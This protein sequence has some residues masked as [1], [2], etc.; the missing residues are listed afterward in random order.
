MTKPHIHF[1]GKNFGDIFEIHNILSKCP[2]FDTTHDFYNT[3]EK[4]GSDGDF[5]ITSH[6]TP[7]QYHG[8]VIHCQH[9]FGVA[10][11]VTYADPVKFKADYCT[12]YYALMLYGDQ[13]AKDYTKVGFPENKI[14]VVG[15]PASI[16]LLEVTPKLK[17]KF[18]NS[19][20]F[21]TDRKTVC[22][23]PSWDMG[24]PRG[25]FALWHKDGKERIRVEKFCKF[26][27]HTLGCNLIIRMH[28][29][30]RYSQDWGAKYNDIFKNY[31]VFFT[32][33]DQQPSFNKA[34]KYSD[35]FVGDYSNTNTYVYIMNKPIVHIGSKPL[36]RW[37]NKNGGWPMEDRDG[38][39]TDDF[40]QL[41]KQIAD[42]LEHPEKFS[43]RRIEVVRKNI[44]YTGTDCI[45][46]VISEF[47]ELILV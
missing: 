45:R 35:I 27:T 9:G 41:L 28:E 39:I 32:Y 25:L 26:I 29:R 47:K 31:N 37:A 11:R 2:E 19:A 13:Q 4:T 16:P 3:G 46:P 24:T 21:N 23:I 20:G 22:Y 17:I 5:V 15:C 7:K 44:K 10:S 36:K 34:L 1:Y 14:A 30:H 43:E 33:L 18:F 38:Y 8:K 42:S 12:Q 40:N 6:N